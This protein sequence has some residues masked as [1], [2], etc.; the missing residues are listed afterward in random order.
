M[1][2][3]LA[4]SNATHAYDMMI[5]LATA[6]GGGILLISVARRLKLAPI[7]ILTLGGFLLGPHGIGWLNPASL[8]DG[9]RVIVSLAM[10]LILFEGGLTLNPNDYKKV[11]GPILRFLTVGVLITWLTTAILIWLLFRFPVSLCLLYGSLVVVTGPTVI[12]PLLQRIR[13]APKLHN[14]LYWEGVLIDPIGVFLALLCFEYIL[15]PQSGQ[16]LLAFFLRV[17]DGLVLGLFGGLFLDFLY[18]RRVI[19][20]DILNVFS[21][22]YA[23]MIFALADSFA[24]EAGLLA[25]TVCGFVVGLRKPPALERLRRFKNEITNLMIGMLFLLLVARLEPTQFLE[26]NWRG[27]LLVALVMLV[28]R[29][30]NVCVSTFRLDMGWREKVF[31]SWLAPRGVVAASMASIVA[32][33]LSD[34]GRIQNPQFLETFVYSVIIATVVIQGF[35][36]GTL[37][38][39]LGLQ[40]PQPTG[41]LIIG[42]HLFGRELARFIRHSENTSAILM[43]S[44]PV[45]VACALEEGLPAMVMDARDTET[46][47]NSPVI[48]SVGRMIALTDN[49][50][51]NALV[52]RRWS[53]I[54]GS[55]NVHFWGMRTLA[56]ESSDRM[57]IWPD[58]PKPTIVCERLN[59]GDA[60]LQTTNVPVHQSHD[61]MHVLMARKKDGSIDLHPR[62]GET[63]QTFLYLHL[64]EEELLRAL[65]PE[66]IAWIQP[67][68]MR[69]LMAQMLTLA[70]RVQ[71]NIDFSALLKKLL[72][73]EKMATTAIGGGV[74]VPHATSPNM[75]RRL[76]LLARVQNEVDF[77]AENQEQIRLVFLLL[78]PEGDP[79]GHLRSL[80]QIA[81]LAGTPRV[82]EQLLQ[83]SNPREILDV[84]A[85]AIR[86]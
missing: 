44:N 35:T 73:R 68:D 36:A 53:R 75:N 54:L 10:G 83:G 80:A 31:L 20:E 43:D 29:P 12:A 57:V 66:C 26:W 34:N 23:V 4:V 47:E 38:K 3:T 25:V 9:L 65:Q 76:C 42:A 16:V 14:I 77:H 45:E 46:I 41:W 62:E 1:P 84:I 32:I 72:D 64:E 18:R 61:V 37:A 70:K 86:H 71:P 30:L 6:L 52:C 21:L 63:G 74:A 22:G 56:M 58:L 49:E 28:V 59:R 7:V 27:Y 40:K 39:Y 81:R 69:D 48:S 55:R 2:A 60:E 5:T 15:E 17:M 33:T 51:L 79:A 13:L 19:P 8:E 82:R 85:E 11:Y 50:D 78:S 24:S 67:R